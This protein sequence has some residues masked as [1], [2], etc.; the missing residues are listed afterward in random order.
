MKIL[1]S[2]L[3]CLLRQAASTAGSFNPDDNFYIIA[4]QLTPCEARYAQAFLTWVHTNNRTF[5]HNVSDVYA[6]FTKSPDFAKAQPT[7]I[8]EE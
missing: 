5:G 6:E 3:N 7:E 4:E 2:K 1:N 8:S